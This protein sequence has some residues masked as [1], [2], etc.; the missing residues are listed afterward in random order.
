MIESVDVLDLPGFLVPRLLKRRFSEFLYEAA[1]NQEETGGLEQ[2]LDDEAEPV[3]PVP[4]RG[5]EGGLRAAPAACSPAARRC[6]ARP[7]SAACPTPTRVVGRACAGR[8]RPRTPGTARGGARRRTL[9]R[10]TRSRS[11]PRPRRRSGTGAR[12]G[13][14]R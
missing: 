11:W 14:C 8:A 4:L 7:A 1:C 5:P 3:P 9:C 2:G 13:A 10:R 12:T 6:S